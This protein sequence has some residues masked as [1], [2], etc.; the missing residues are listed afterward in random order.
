MRRGP[1]RDDAFQRMGHIDFTLGLLSPRQS[2]MA[3][4]VEPVA[5]ARLDH[6]FDLCDAFSNP[7]VLDQHFG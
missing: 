2:P 3:R 6:L 7:G 4:S 1:R 5:V